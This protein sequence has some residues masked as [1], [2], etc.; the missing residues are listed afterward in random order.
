LLCAS[1]LAFGL[2]AVGCGDEKLPQGPAP[3]PT[4]F[5]LTILQTS[6]VH[7]HAAGVGAATDY[8]PLTRSNDTVSGGYA[9]IAQVI[10]SER[11]SSANPVLVLDSGDFLMGTLY[12][13]TMASDPL[14]LRFIQSMPYD[15]ITLGNHEFDYGPDR[16]AAFVS[17][18]KS[19]ASGGFTVPIVASNMDASANTALKAHVTSGAIVKK[20]VKTLAN[21]LKI[22]ILGLMGPTAAGYAP[23]A[24]PVTFANGASAHD[25]A[26]V[27]ALVN[28]LRSTDGAKLAGL[29]FL[30]GKLSN[31]D[32][33]LN[34]S[35]VQVLHNNGYFGPAAVYK[36]P[37]MGGLN[38]N[39]PAASPDPAN[40]I[41][42]ADTT[43]LYRVVVDLYT[44]LMMYQVN[45][46]YPSMALGVY[47]KN[48]T[49]VTYTAA[50]APRFTNNNKTLRAW[51]ALAAYLKGLSTQ[52]GGG[53]ISLAGYKDGGAA[54]GREQPR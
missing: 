29:S 25:Y 8:T 50:T 11:Q 23:L 38:G 1:A 14:A 27:Q 51:Q 30:V 46:L 31:S 4:S 34:L 20:V 10:Q 53:N 43:T 2:T 28:E 35:G 54:M 17:A 19:S 40:L 52:L 37:V 6:D 9:R 48:G 18:S 3:G 16:L 42:P 7:H 13:M 12:D 47:D 21:G 39:N 36:C 24:A 45:A 15:P 22:G 5:S 32:F 33:Y 26:K 41:N 44:L 49:A